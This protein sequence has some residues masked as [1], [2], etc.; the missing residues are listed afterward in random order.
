VTHNPEGPDGKIRNNVVVQ[1]ERNKGDVDKPTPEQQKALDNL[2]KYEGQRIEDQ[3]PNGVK[4]VTLKDGSHVKQV[5]IDDPQRLIGDKT[6]RQMGD[7]IPDG[8]LGSSAAAT[9]DIQR[10][11]RRTAGRVGRVGGS[12][13]GSAVIDG[14]QANDTFNDTNSI[15]NTPIAAA[16]D[17]IGALQGDKT[18]PYET[19]H[20]NNDGTSSVGR[21]GFNHRNFS[22]MMSHVM[23][24]DIMAKLGN[25]P[26]WSKLGDILKDPNMMQEYQGAMSQAAQN[27]DIPKDF[28]KNMQDPNYV[29]GFGKMVEGMNGNGPA[30]TAADLDKYLPKGTQDGLAQSM[31]NGYAKEMGM[32]PNQLKDG[33]AGKLA[34]A[35]YLGHPPN[36]QEQ[37]NPAYRDYMQAADNVNHIAQ[38]RQDGTGDVLVHGGNGK[39]A[40]VAA[41]LEG[42]RL[43]AK[44][45]FANAVEG[46]NL[47]CA[48]SVS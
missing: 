7:R 17:T 28:A 31:V 10:E 41:N 20:H 5:D 6:M 47:G 43:W 42:Q 19:V 45:Q 18:H 8:Q 25:P 21:Y 13:G 48:A 16:T 1:L 22:H 34:L 40:A 38:A 46:G 39:I 32:N 30:P 26:D 14:N 15:G 11:A 3:N 37:N 35:M 24:A 36:P 44:T 4:D 12:G 2:V 29:Q 9:P 33:D 23:P 27:G